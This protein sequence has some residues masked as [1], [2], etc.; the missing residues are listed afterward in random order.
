MTTREL[1]NELEKLPEDRKIM[2]INI[3]N[4]TIHDISGVEEIR[5]GDIIVN[6]ITMD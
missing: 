2:Y 3:N 5:I 4:N 1:I 6:A